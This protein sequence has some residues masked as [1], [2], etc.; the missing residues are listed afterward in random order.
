[1]TQ[2]IH[3]GFAENYIAKLTNVAQSAHFGASRRQ[4]TLHAGMY[5][6]EANSIPHTF[7]SVYDSLQHGPAVMWT[8]L[9]P[10]L[11]E[12]LSSS[13]VHFFSDGPSAQY[14]QKLNFIFAN[15]I[16]YLVQKTAIWN[17]FESGQGKG[18]P[19]G[20]GAAVKKADD[21]TVLGGHDIVSAKSLYEHLLM[22]KSSVLH[23][24]SSC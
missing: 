4:K 8:H 22:E 9:Q 14:R 3:I 13:H 10:V 6:V 18:I 7:C 20:I 16:Q 12:I 5:Y 2:L 23:S 17:F 24:S 19:D 11:S 1:M 21:R 15:V